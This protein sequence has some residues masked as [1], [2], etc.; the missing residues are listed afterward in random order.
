M[1]DRSAMRTRRTAGTI[2]G[3]AAAAPA[4]HAAPE[5]A[6]AQP[7][8]TRSVLEPVGTRQLNVRIPVVL[9]R[10]YRHLLRDL[11]DAGIETSMTEL[12]NAVLCAAP[13]DA[14]GARE[15]LRAPRVQS[16]P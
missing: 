16:A 12:V 6:D 2:P 4:P 10:R 5:V 14:A 1:P 8:D 3:F 9:H 11:E 7:V 13:A 15:L